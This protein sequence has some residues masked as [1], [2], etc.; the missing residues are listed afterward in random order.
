MLFPNV[1]KTLKPKGLGGGTHKPT[2]SA[3][4]IFV[5]ARRRVHGHRHVV[6]VGGRTHSVGLHRGLLRHLPGQ[7]RTYQRQRFPRTR[8]R[9][10]HAVASLQQCKRRNVHADRT[11]RPV[12][13]ARFCTTITFCRHSRTF[14]MYRRCTSYGSYGKST[15]TPLHSN[16]TIS[17]IV[18]PGRT[19]AGGAWPMYDVL[20]YD[21]HK[22]HAFYA[23]N[24]RPGERS[25]A[26]RK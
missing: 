2:P 22:K 9:L 17:S 18:F 15:S 13:R 8:G 7:R 20:R 5:N 3:V 24:K 14:S 25:N 4:W 6:V 21:A 10:Q 12:W 11:G 1:K 26:L 16:E 23:K 19:H